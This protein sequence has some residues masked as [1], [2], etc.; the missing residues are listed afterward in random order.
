M[1][2]PYSFKIGDTRMYAEHE[3]NGIAKQLKPK[4]TIE[5]K[6]FKKSVLEEEQLPL[7]MDMMLADFEKMQHPQLE[8]LAF[9][10]LDIFR[11]T[12]SRF[13]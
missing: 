4:V 3:G 1:L 2:T 8:S 11:K 13:P 12:N 6:P 5:F 10:A 9:E 7:D